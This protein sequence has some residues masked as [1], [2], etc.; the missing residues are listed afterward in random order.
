MAGERADCVVD[1]QA[2]GDLAAAEAAGGLRVQAAAWA[3]AD[4]LPPVGA[5]F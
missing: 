4:R 1:F 3:A 5:G 2:V